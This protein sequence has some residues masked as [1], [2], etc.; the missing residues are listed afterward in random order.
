MMDALVAN[1]PPRE[2][3]QQRS[4]DQQGTSRRDDR[5]AL[6]RRVIRLVGCPWQPLV[7]AEVDDCAAAG[8]LGVWA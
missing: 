6:L 8:E 7:A 1:L 5:Q 3:R 2:A 4:G